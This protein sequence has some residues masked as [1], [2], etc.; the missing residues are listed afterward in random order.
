VIRHS[1]KFASLALAGLWLA[2]LACAGSS[3]VAPAAVSAVNISAV[4]IGLESGQTADL[5]A[6]VLGADGQAFTDGTVTWESSNPAVVHIA[7]TGNRTATLSAAG[8]GVANISAAIE[9]QS[10]IASVTVAALGQTKGITAS[11]VYTEQEGL[12]FIPLP[13]GATEIKANAINDLG[14]VV[15]EVSYGTLPS[16]AFLWSR[17]DGMRDL[18]VI[19]GSKWRTV[20]TAISQ[21]G[22]VAGYGT[23]ADNH[24]H[25]FRWTRATGIVDLGVSPGAVNSFVT[26]INIGGQ[27][28]G[29]GDGSGIRPF[30]WSE[31]RGMENLAST[32]VPAMAFAINGAGQ[33]AGAL[34]FG[35]DYIGDAYNAASFWSASGVRTDFLKCTSPAGGCGAAAFAINGGGVVAG[36]DGSHALIWSSDSGIRLLSGL[37]LGSEAIGIND[38]GT[39]VG[40]FFDVDARIG[41]VWSASAGAR[42]VR[43]PSARKAI[44]FTGVNNKDQIVGWVQ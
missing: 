40:N 30:R 18:G 22:Q 9:R 21:D 25:A 31:D 24:T 10:A 16:H 42:I 7:S 8:A 19:A 12:A 17:S 27:V 28:V 23:V 37:P 35:E 44:H 33:V 20:A 6:T 14:Q 2:S 5:T 36:T 26:G 13:S 43:P 32:T 1:T 34:I 4:P 38:R 3:S 11:F 41:F 29:W 15:G 39:V